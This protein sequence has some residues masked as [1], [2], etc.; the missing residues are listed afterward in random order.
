M[1][2]Q[3]NKDYLVYMKLSENNTYAD[4]VSATYPL[5]I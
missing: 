1:K 5:L 2:S 4:F 3:Q